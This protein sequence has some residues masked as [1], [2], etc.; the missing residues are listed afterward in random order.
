MYKMNVFFSVFDY[1]TEKT[2]LT[3][4]LLRPNLLFPNIIKNHII[5]VKIECNTM[6]IPRTDVINS[7]SKEKRDA[8]KLIQRNSYNLERQMRLI[9]R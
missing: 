2:I 1:S 9:A 8:C 5:C 7:V 6:F 4:I 3:S